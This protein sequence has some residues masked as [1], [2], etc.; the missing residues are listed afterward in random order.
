VSQGHERLCGRGIVSR[1][2]HALVGIFQP[3]DCIYEL[4]SAITFF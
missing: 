4:T 2:V 3:A 1:N